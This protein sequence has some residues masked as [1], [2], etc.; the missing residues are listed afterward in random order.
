MQTKCNYCKKLSNI[1]QPGNSCDKCSVGTMQEYIPPVET[2]E[3]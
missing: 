2:K 1:K 3:K